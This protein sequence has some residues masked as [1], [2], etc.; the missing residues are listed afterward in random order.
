MSGY[1]AADMRVC[2][3]ARPSNLIDYRDTELLGPQS[4]PAA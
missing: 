3:A 1:A 2:S 4:S